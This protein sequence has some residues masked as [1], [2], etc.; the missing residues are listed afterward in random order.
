MWQAD[1]L[2][3]V[4]LTFFAAGLVKGVVGLGLPTIVLGML[5]VPLGITQAIAVLLVP[6]LVTNAVQGFTGPK[7]L[8]NA[9]RFWPLLAAASL[10]I[11]VGTGALA[12]SSGS[13]PA[14]ALGVLIALHG[15]I[16]L[17]APPLP[18]PGRHERWLS[19]VTGLANG[20]ITGF[21]GSAILPGVLYFQSLGLD[22][23]RLVQGMGLLFCVSTAILMV[24]FTRYELLTAELALLSTLALVPALLGL[25][26]GAKVRRRIAEERFRRLLFVALIVLGVGIVWRTTA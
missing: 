10:G 19:P 6:S 22:K 1:T 25:W 8:A 5:T 15:A 11:L 24:A 20:L 23:E 7:A 4:T 17:L 3:L 9:K 18:H 12:R 16:S 21:T 13:G 14:V 26:L 2:I